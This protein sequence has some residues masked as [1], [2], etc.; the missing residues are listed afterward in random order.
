[1]NLSSCT[2]QRAGRSRRKE[3]SHFL[4]WST[5]LA[6]AILTFLWG[7]GAGVAEDTDA[8]PLSNLE[9]MREI[10]KDLGVKAGE[11]IPGSKGDTI[12][13]VVR[14][15]ETSWYVEASLLRGLMDCGYLVRTGE[16][17]GL[18]AH[19]G[20]AEL[21]VRYTDARS[22]GLFGETVVNR[23]VTVTISTKILYN[24]TGEV[25]FQEDLA[26]GRS[27]TVA[28]SAI[29]TL[30]NPNIAVTRGELPAEGFFSGVAGPLIVLGALG[31]A[32]YLL[33]HVRS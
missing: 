21:G 32:V 25:V 11:L 5:R 13:A 30:E 14:P 1:M 3:G 9:M 24:T 27:D 12:S 20:I 26:G 10:A 7:S 17:E 4:R 18:V 15:A 33:F 2:A 22:E 31:V 6:V 23:H 19:F 8:P 16:G 28:L 29:G